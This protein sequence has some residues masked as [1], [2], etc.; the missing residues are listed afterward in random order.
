MGHMVFDKKVMRVN[1]RVNK[2]V[3]D[4]IDVMFGQHG[5]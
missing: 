1:R 5:Q 2:P 4:F 3:F